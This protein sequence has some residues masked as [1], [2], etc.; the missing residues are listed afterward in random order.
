MSALVRLCVFLL[1]PTF[2]CLAVQPPMLASKSIQ[3][4][5]ELLLASTISAEECNDGNQGGNFSHFDDIDCTTRETRSAFDLVALEPNGDSHLPDTKRC[6][7]E[8]CFQPPE[9]AV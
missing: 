4:S 3:F 6:L 7:L 5:T 1:L 8:S 9:F 2:I